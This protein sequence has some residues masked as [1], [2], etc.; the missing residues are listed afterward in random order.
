[1][2]VHVMKGTTVVIFALVLVL[3]IPVFAGDIEIAKRYGV[4]G[5]TPTVSNEA[6]V[7]PAGT[8]LLPGQLRAIESLLPVTFM[9]TAQVRELGPS[10]VNVENGGGIAAQ[11]KELGPSFVN[12]ENGG[13]IT[14]QVK[15]LGPSFI[16]IENGGGGITA[17]V[18]K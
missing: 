2:E 5:E 8:Q 17:Q 7:L 12:V 14:A 15:E 16:N 10:F 1:M 13:G 11:V 9:D 4:K 18:K 3:S 6:G